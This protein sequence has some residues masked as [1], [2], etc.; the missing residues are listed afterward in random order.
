MAD[1]MDRMFDDFGRGRRWTTPWRETGMEAWAPDIDVFQKDNELTIR[2]D[3]PG[4]KR[5]EVSVDITDDAVT[6]Q[7]ERKR[8]KE[9]ERE[10]YYRSERSYGSL[11]RLAQGT[12]TGEPARALL[13]GIAAH[14]MIPLDMRPSGGVALALAVAAHVA[15]WCIPRGNYSRGRRGPRTPPRYQVCISVRRRH[16]PVSAC[17]ECAGSVP[18]SARFERS[19][20]IENKGCYSQPWGRSLCT[21]TPGVRILLLS[22]HRKRPRRKIGLKWSDITVLLRL[23]KKPSPWRSCTRF[24]RHRVRR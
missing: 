11:A 7:G 20:A 12:F 10:G 9:E 23:S 8:E 19:F 5:D 18:R 2:A 17:M 22:S 3:L 15:G 24:P 1:E 21:V 13:A 6:I 14:S 4:L 16:H